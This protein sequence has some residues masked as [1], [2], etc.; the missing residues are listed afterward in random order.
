MS[1]LAAEISD[2]TRAGASRP[3]LGA[4]LQLLDIEAALDVLAEILLTAPDPSAECDYAEP[5]ARA[6][7][8]YAKEQAEI[9]VPMRQLFAM[10]RESAT[11]V[12]HEVGA[13][14]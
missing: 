8:A 3:A 6:S 2:V 1:R 14:G 4:T 7:N 12:T 10:V 13:F 5:A 11:A 9:F